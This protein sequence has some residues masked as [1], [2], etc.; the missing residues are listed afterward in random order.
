[1]GMVFR[2]FECAFEHRWQKLVDRGSPPPDECPICTAVVAAIDP[3]HE[4]ARARS[5]NM[6]SP[7]IRG[8]RTKAIARFE[9]G[10]MVRPHFDDG[11]PLMTNLKDNVRE[12]ETY[13]VPETVSSSET[14]RMTKQMIEARQQA[15]RTTEGAHAMVP[16]GGGWQ[17]PNATTL[18]AAGGPQNPMG[19]EVVNLQGKRA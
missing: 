15:G 9:H 10:A 2:T 8:A 1:M 16:M 11:S 6:P 18:A 7:G 17:P 4:P 13:A 12:G 5:D 14:M 19:R 3:P